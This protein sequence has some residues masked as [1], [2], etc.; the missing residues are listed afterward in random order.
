M[1]NIQDYAILASVERYLLPEVFKTLQNNNQIVK[2]KLESF[3]E[4]NS[5]YI[6]I[7]LNGADRKWQ[8]LGST[9]YLQRTVVSPSE[10]IK[11]FGNATTK[12]TNQQ[13]TDMEVFKTK[14]VKINGADRKVTVAVT[15]TDGK[16]GA[17]YSIVHKDDKFNDT[18]GKT[19]AKGRA[20]N[21]RSNLVDMTMG[22]GM[23][24]KYILYSIA[25]HIFRQLENG[26]IIIKGIK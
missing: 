14:V 16:I 18:I 17:G 7:P 23:E 22:I 24:K 11:L 9:S 8:S 3:L 2:R 26:K 6:G 13:T 19:V 25:D 21:E 12:Q 20:L 10:F 4:Y 5:D 1:K 15:V